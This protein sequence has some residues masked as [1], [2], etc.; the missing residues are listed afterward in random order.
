MLTAAT[1]MLTAFV[2]RTVACTTTLVAVVAVPTVPG[3]D[4]WLAPAGTMTEAGTESS[5][6]LELLSL[7]MVPPT[8]A[9]A[10]RTTVT[11]PV[12]PEVMVAADDRLA[13]STAGG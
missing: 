10:V 3:T 4:A 8:G 11:L 2:V 7:T 12:V 1:C 9:A 13:I 6:A 5:A